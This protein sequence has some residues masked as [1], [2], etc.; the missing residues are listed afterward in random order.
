MAIWCVKTCGAW[1]ISK[2]RFEITTSFSSGKKKHIKKSTVHYSEIQNIMFWWCKSFPTVFY[3]IQGTVQ[4][5]K[6][7]QNETLKL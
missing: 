5:H 4:V 7:L 6:N 3:N 2:G 1:D